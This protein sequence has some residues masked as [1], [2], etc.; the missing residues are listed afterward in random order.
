MKSRLALRGDVRWKS[1]GLNHGE[2]IA[3][4]DPD[5]GEIR[6]GGMNRLQGLLALVIETPGARSQFCTV[7]G[8]SV[9]KPAEASSSSTIR[10]ESEKDPAGDM[11][12]LCLSRDEPLTRSPQ[13]I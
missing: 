12:R 5:L 2:G 6:A 1:A 13:E 10:A 9:K 11:A 8:V 7:S 4:L 3:G